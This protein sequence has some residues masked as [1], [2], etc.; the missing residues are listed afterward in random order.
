MDEQAYFEIINIRYPKNFEKIQNL[1]NSMLHPIFEL[2]GLSEYSLIPFEDSIEIY[3]KNFYYYQGDEVVCKDTWELSHS[4]ID[5]ILNNEVYIWNG[6]D[7]IPAAD[8]V[9]VEIKYGVTEIR[10]AAFANCDSLVSITI[11]NS[12]TAIGDEVFYYCDSL[13]SITIPNSVKKIGL[14][15]FMHCHSL[16][17]I[18]IPNGV[19]KIEMQTFFS[20]TSL[21]SITIPDSVKKIEKGAFYNCYSLTS[22][23]IPNSVT[24]IGEAAFYGC[25]SLT[26]ISIPKSVKKIEEEVFKKCDKLQIIYVENPDLI[27][28]L[29]EEYPNI[30]IIEV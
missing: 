18:I 23:T 2:E 28:Y 10:R 27:P 4:G 6:K 1:R 11:P 19:K 16:T 9:F 5:Q 14:G 24:E 25:K 7:K 22:I 12:V 20:C 13:P 8:V 21:S 26:S 30:D 3:G 17:S 15:A 29:K